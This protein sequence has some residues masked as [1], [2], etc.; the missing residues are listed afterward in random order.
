MAIPGVSPLA[1]LQ[2]A[3]ASICAQMRDVLANPKPT[4]TVP[5]GATLN[6]E[7]YYASLAEREE[8]LR[9]IP[10]VAPTTN[11]VFEVWG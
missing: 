11:P 2:A 6:W 3:Y 7:A 4:Y 1:D 10:G 9:K 5:G 8:A